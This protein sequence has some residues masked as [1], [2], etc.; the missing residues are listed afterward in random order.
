M[1]AAKYILS[2]GT[3]SLNNVL[4][5]LNIPIRNSGFVI[6]IPHITAV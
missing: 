4:S 3:A 1:N 2:A 6:I 5:E